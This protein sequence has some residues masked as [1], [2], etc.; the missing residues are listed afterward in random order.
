[1]KQDVILV[2]ALVI[3]LGT[4]VLLSRWTDRRHAD[5]GQ[6][7]EQQLYVSGPAAKRLTL[8]FNGLAADWYWMRSLQYVGRKVVA[9]E[10]SHEGQFDLN[11]LSSLDLRL[12]PSLLSVT[13]T[14]DPQFLPAYEYGAMILSEVNPEEAI[15]LLNRGI[16]S[17]PNSWRLYQ[18]LGYVYWQ[19]RDY[20]KASTVYATGAKLPGAPEWM[21]ALSA[22]MKADGGS[23]DAGREMYQRLSEA[24][25]DNAVKEMVAHQI[26]RLDWLDDRDVISKLIGD[27]RVQ[28]GHCPQTWRDLANRFRGTRIRINSAGGAPLDP[29]GVPYRLIDGGCNVELDAKSKVPRV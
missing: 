3:G 2:A 5:S 6:F 23:R 7:S 24:S 18:H 12:L 19:R 4:V 11:N 20:E 8:A 10:D 14:L 16:A 9:Y 1:M 28:T 26:M 17:N 13:T 15:S 22:R 25:N 27:Y 29:S 21:A